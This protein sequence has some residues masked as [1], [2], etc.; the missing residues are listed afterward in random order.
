MKCP[1]CRKSFQYKKDVVHHLQ[2]RHRTD[3]PKD[4][5]PAKYLFSRLHGGRTTGSC[6]I[7]SNETM[8]DERTGRTKVFCEN[9]KC[10]EAFAK[11]AQERNMKAF[12]VPHLLGNQQ[13]Q[14][15]MLSRRK[16]S[17][18]YEWSDHRTK[19]PYV[20]SYERKFLEF[21][22]TFL[23]FDPSTIHSPCPITV[24]YD[25]H[26]E[27]LS[28]TPDF[29]ID[30]LDLIVEI[31][32]G[33][34]N[35]NTHP[36]IQAI[37]VEKD[38]AKEAAIQAL[39]NNYIK[40][41]DND[42]EPL[43]KALFTLVE[44]QQYE[45][46]Q[47]LFIIN[48]S[49]NIEESGSDFTRLSKGNDLYISVFLENVANVTLDHKTVIHFNESYDQAIVRDST[50]W[51][52]SQISLQENFPRN[53]VMVKYTGDM[54]ISKEIEILKTDLGNSTSGYNELELLKK[55]FPSIFQDKKITSINQLVLD[56][57]FSIVKRGGL[58]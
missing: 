9:P 16:I 45:T 13:H 53:G 1:V 35:P 28:H 52:Y 43:L 3:I 10:K 21:M 22:D 23:D 4:M 39:T 2:I 18:V 11:I 54:N 14:M 56:H 40:I 55:F 46:K 12:G 37:D 42:F 36:K 19:I 34:A 49:G 8:F 51:N 17:G 48:E 47:R 15:F 31:K 24:Y 29:Y 7:C 30:I 20:G 58:L 44:D 57:D 33:G 50:E 27:T 5:S 25:Y 38:K 6:R 41:T 26:G 32:H